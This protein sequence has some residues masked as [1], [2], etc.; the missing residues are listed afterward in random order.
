MRCNFH[1]WKCDSEPPGSGMDV[2]GGEQAPFH[3]RTY[4]HDLL[5][6]VYACR[7]YIPYVI[8]STF[9][10]FLGIGGAAP[11][12]R[13]AGTCKKEPHAIFVETHYSGG[14][15]QPFRG[16]TLSWSGASGCRR[17]CLSLILCLIALRLRSTE[18]GQVTFSPSS[19]SPSNYLR[20]GFPKP[21]I[22]ASSPII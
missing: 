4:Q 1:D 17:K 16:I 22:S 11:C 20:S 18:R 3:N 5:V 19:C 8:V 13:S 21:Y 15:R 14:T 6:R 7:V 9:G 10:L 12:L 2:R